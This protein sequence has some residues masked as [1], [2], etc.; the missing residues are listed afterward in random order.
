MAHIMITLIILSSKIEK[1]SQNLKEENLEGLEIIIIN[2]KLLLL[3]YK[4]NISVVIENILY[5]IYIIYFSL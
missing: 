2:L 3:N 5:I 4:Q 1:I